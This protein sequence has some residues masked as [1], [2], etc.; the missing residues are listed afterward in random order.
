MFDGGLLGLGAGTPVTLRA[1]SLLTF[2]LRTGIALPAIPHAPVSTSLSED[3]TGTQG[4]F[5]AGCR[6][7]GLSGLVRQATSVRRAK[8][9]RKRA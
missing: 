8:V 4:P 9:I 7:T 1:G 5:Y 3:D 6:N 2:G